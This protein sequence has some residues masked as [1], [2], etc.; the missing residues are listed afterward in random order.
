MRDEI[1]KTVEAAINAT[2]KWGKDETVCDPEALKGHL[3]SKLAALHSVGA[4][5]DAQMAKIMA[6]LIQAYWKVAKKLDKQV[7]SASVLRNPQLST[8]RK[9]S[10]VQLSAWRTL[11]P[12]MAF[13]NPFF[14]KSEISFDIP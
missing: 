12:D 11:G 9:A 5:N 14:F 10:H 1:T 8:Y 13:A 4:S 7:R 6:R 3:L 2:K